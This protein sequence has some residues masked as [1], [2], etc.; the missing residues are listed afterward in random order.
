MKRG[1]LILIITA[2]TA[3]AAA[4]ARLVLWASVDA[5]HLCYTPP[6]PT[7]QPSYLPL[8]LPFR[9]ICGLQL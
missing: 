4:V 1:A 8:P 3:K 7:P 2:V 9:A 6:Q 5:V